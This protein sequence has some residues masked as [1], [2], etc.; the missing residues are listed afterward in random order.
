M[1]KIEMKHAGFWDRVNKHVI[2][3]FVP[4]ILFFIALDFL[5][6]DKEILA[7][8][9]WAMMAAYIIGYMLLRKRFVHLM[10]IDDNNQPATIKQKMWRGFINDFP[11]I[12]YALYVAFNLF[13]RREEM[14][15]SDHI[16]CAIENG[17][18][19][20]LI[21]SANMISPI[22]VIM[23]PLP[24]LLLTYIIYYLPMALPSCR[25]ALH[26]MISKTHVVYSEP[27]SF[28]LIRL[29]LKTPI[30]LISLAII[31]LPFY[32]SAWVI[33]N[34]QDKPLDP[35]V[36]AFFY[37]DPFNA[38]NNVHVALTG[39]NAP[40]D[41]ADIYAYGLKIVNG[42][43]KL[44]KHIEFIG[45]PDNLCYSQ[46]G[47]DI[48]NERNCDSP[49]TIKQLF[50]DNKLIIDRYIS[51]YSYGNHE[52]GDNWGKYYGQNIISIKK[53]L[54]PNWIEMARS[55]NGEEA[56]KWWLKDTKFAQSMIGSKGTIVAQAIWMVIYGINL[57][58]LPL[59]FEANPT[60]I[61]KYK[62]E[63]TALLDKDYLHGIWNVE[64]TWRAEY[65][66]FRLM[67]LENISHYLL[68]IKPNDLRNRFI[69]LARDSIAISKL[70]PAEIGKQI[71]I[72]KK[73]HKPKFM[74]PP[75]HLSYNIIGEI[76][77]GDF[78]RGSEIY[79]NAHN[80]TAHH[81]SLILWMEA[82]SQNI[83]AQD[84]KEFLANSASKYYDP[85][86]ETPFSWDAKTKSIFWNKIYTDDE[87]RSDLYYEMPDK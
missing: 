60:L 80:M 64:D 52:I 49:E 82:K 76:I 35:Q 21:F 14:L 42:K 48:A 69:N 7:Y 68:I 39:L 86:T 13:F 50:D 47:Y 18:C 65:K 6:N 61:T 27:K 63:I 81:R 38:E 16:F 72:L 62:D 45:E 17:E 74:D 12:I 79:I 32:I 56:I 3:I 54:A 20:D 11:I 9:L 41:E 33:Y 71:P 2:S 4:V 36:E 59:I 19:D 28:S 55:G 84:M 67:N 70:P 30:L 26:D 75:Y 22:E 31:F 5:S 73:K 29:T 57:A 23:L 78:I 40:A 10:L 83:A 25:R 1:S 53:L 43:I 15:F 51:L 77:I 8:S 87:Y 85:F 44:E 34:F 24:L 58:A 66:G 46:H 37:D